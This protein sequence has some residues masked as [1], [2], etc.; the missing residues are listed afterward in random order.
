MG[1]L[2]TQAELEDRM[3]FGGIQRA[4]AS[5]ANAEENGA[6]YRNPY[7]K[8]I[9]RTFVLPLASAIRAATQSTRPGRLQ[10]HASLLQAL[11][12]DAVAL[13]TVRTVL[14]FLMNPNVENELPAL[15]A[16]LGATIHGELVLEQIANDMPDLYHV[17]TRDFARRLS[18]SERH[19]LTVYKMQARD[20]GLMLVEWPV[21]ARQQVGY[22]LLGLLEV[23]GMIHVDPVPP[24]VHG[25]RP[26][27]GVYL[28]L[29]VLERIEQIKSL[30]VL[31]MPAYGPCSEPPRPWVSTWDGG[32]HTPR[33]RRNSPC[34]VKCRAGVRHLYREAQMPVVL[35]AVNA[36]QETPWAVNTQVL[37][38][39]IEAAK[40]FST[41]EIVSIADT[42]KPEQ[43]AWLQEEWTKTLKREEWPKDKAEE[44][45]QW[46]RVTAE[47]YTQ[48]K[49]LGT[50]YG[51]FYAATRQAEFFR[52]Y[53]AIY[54]VYFADSRGR[55]YPMTSGLSPQG[56]DLQKALLR[57]ATG[58]PLDTPEA[59]RWFHVQGANKWGFDKAPLATRHQWVV[60]RQELIL[61]MADDPLNNRD[62]TQA[63]KPLQFLAWAFEYARYVRDTRGTFLS[64]LPV[65]M[66]GSCN[67]LQNL[68]AL[69]RDEVGGEATNLIPSEEMQ[70]I[71]ARVAAA[72]TVRME[73]HRYEDAAK[74]TLR[75][76]WLAHGIGRS[77]VKRP[78]MTTPYGVTRQAAVKYV[79][80]DYLKEC[81]TN[82]SKEEF[83]QA[84]GVLMDH[85]WPA[86]G[87]VVVKGRE[88]MA[89]LRKAASI[90]VRGIPEGEEPV[91]WWTSPSGFVASQSY[92]EVETA[93][94]HTRLHGEERIRVAFESEEPDLNEHANGLAPNFVHSM[95]AAHLHL[96]T[97]LA[98][99]RGIDA[100]AMIHDDYGT[101]PANAQALF[102][103]IREAFVTMYESHDPIADFEKKYPGLPPAPQKGTLDIRGV[104]R[105]P[106]FFS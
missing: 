30:V 60:D 86:I 23:A 2:L 74:E 36:L 88:C 82:F 41:K 106:Y 101:H 18:K 96:T 25:K 105:S 5:I 57:F 48:R 17:L 77:V 80:L 14:A 37:D 32:F 61:A 4:T 79:V 81:A 53:P 20:K 99:R 44:F 94:I 39:V 52:D 47:W 16:Q 93:R 21:G 42:P 100:L 3:H 10:A 56:S 59:V 69:L 40:R 49:L 13:L 89:W 6:A 85:A 75:Q 24:A 83:K 63:D 55:L 103:C 95:D 64:H 15:S 19:R 26:R 27:R 22:Y 72:T 38:T 58:M 76:K 70:D 43:P 102:E 9:L 1:Q 68:S 50:R 104:L 46:K 90:I 91:I 67:G 73:A 11:D 78:V 35:E 87:D 65:S 51:R 33:M 71:Y 92:F 34:L 97:Q 29:E 66:D 8:E 98:R 12:P 28:S 54:F 84:A 7:A 31:T 45:K 62:W